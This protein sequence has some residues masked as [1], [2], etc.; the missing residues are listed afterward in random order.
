MFFLFLPAPASANEE[1]PDSELLE[2]IG[3]WADADKDW[4]DPVDILDMNIDTKEEV[5]TER[6]Q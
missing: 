3:E 2:Y 4:S 6:T 5:V 1:Q